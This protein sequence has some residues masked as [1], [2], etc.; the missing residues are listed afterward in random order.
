VHSA[1][2]KAYNGYCSCRAHT[3]TKPVCELKTQTTLMGDYSR[4]IDMK[5]WSYSRMYIT[6]ATGYCKCKNQN[7]QCLDKNG[8][9][10]NVDRYGRGRYIMGDDGQCTHGSN[11]C[12]RRFNLKADGSINED[13]VG[14]GSMYVL[15]SDGSSCKCSPK[16]GY[17]FSREMNSCQ[18]A[19]STGSTPMPARNVQTNNGTKKAWFGVDPNNFCIVSQDPFLGPGCRLWRQGHK[20]R[21]MR[22]LHAVKAPYV[23]N[24]LKQAEADDKCYKGKNGERII[25]VPSRARRTSTCFCATNSCPDNQTPAA[26]IKASHYNTLACGGKPPLPPTAPPTE[27][28]TASPTAAP[29][30]TVNGT[31]NTQPAT[32]PPP[33][34][35]TTTEADKDSRPE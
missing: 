27:P 20:C 19:V 5:S 7:S 2:E 16:G 10:H 22:G 26:V 21:G 15:A 14:V 25:L 8:R 3:P 23:E 30:G 9:C 33:P 35:T 12:I 28:P 24:C 18:K 11:Y 32:T 31:N 6:D 34:T 4:C 1:F 13:P 17:C 29:N